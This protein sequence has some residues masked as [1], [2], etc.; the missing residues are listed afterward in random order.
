MSQEK[1]IRFDEKELAEIIKSLQEASLAVSS[2]LKT[3]ENWINYRDRI[4]KYL[5]ELREFAKKN[6]ATQF[7]IQASIGIPFKVDVGLT[8]ALKD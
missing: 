5:K 2:S 1:E 4:E 3:E 6:K 8:F 7:N